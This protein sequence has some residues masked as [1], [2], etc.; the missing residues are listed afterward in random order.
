MGSG[1]PA[2]GL[3]QP[4]AGE[5]GPMASPAAW[6]LVTVVFPLWVLAGLAD[7]ACHRATHIDR[8]SGWTENRLHLL[9]FAQMGVAVLAVALLELTAG[10]LVLVAAA[11]VLHEATVWWDLHQTV[12]RRHVGPLEQMVHSFQEVLPLAMLL[13]VGVLAWDQVLALAGA[14]GSADFGLRWKREPLPAPLLAAG[15]LAVLLFNAV[16]LALET[17]ACLRQR[18]AAS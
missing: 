5:N 15:G 9:M 18:R 11:F 17:R 6:L 3:R 10:V 14:A 8:T 12:P 16:P 1:P 2:R 13:L 7:L 4:L